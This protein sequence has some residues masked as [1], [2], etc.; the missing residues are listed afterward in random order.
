MI[1][2]VAKAGGSVTELAPRTSLQD[3][4]VSL[5]IDTTYVYWTDSGHQDV[6]KV[7]IAG[8]A[9]EVLATR[10]EEPH[11]IAVNATH[12]Y[13]AATTSGRV[14]RQPLAGGEV[15]TVASGLIAPTDLALDAQNVYVAT[16]GPAS[17][18]AAVQR[19]QGSIV[20]VPLEGGEAMALTAGLPSPSCL[21]LRANFIYWVN[22]GDSFKNGSLMRVPIGGGRA[23]TLVSNITNGGCIAVDEA[24][25]YW[26][27]SDDAPGGLGTKGAVFKVPIAGGPT[28][29]VVTGLSDVL[30]VSVDATN[31]YWAEGGRVGKV[32][33]SIQ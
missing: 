27:V 13:W 6:R 16:W 23:D 17:E 8:G 4:P 20:K 18:D 28:S 14:L 9:V 19:T 24:S 15:Q 22:V 11:G 33:K 12:I 5:A 10:Q 30:G 7:P 26:A 29:L 3:Q 21:E 32:A 1:G 25:V 2:T 31:V